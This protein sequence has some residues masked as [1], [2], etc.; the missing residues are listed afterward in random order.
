MELHGSTKPKYFNNRTELDRE[1]EVGKRGR[2][3]NGKV[4]QRGGGKGCD[5]AL[6]DFR[7]IAGN[8]RNL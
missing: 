5:M 1:E 7:I 6:F 8:K 3:G 2:N 4:D